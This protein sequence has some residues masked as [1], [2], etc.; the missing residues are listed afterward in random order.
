[1]QRDRSALLGADDH[2]AE[3]GSIG[4][5]HWRYPPERVSPGIVGTK[6]RLNN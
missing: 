3:L 4:T 6:G 1:M 2:E 5:R